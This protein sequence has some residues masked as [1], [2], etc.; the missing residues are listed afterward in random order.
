MTWV[1]DGCVTFDQSALPSA[2]IADA[3]LHRRG[4]VAE[5][6]VIECGGIL[7][8]AADCE[9]QERKE[10]HVAV[11]MGEARAEG[12]NNQ[13]RRDSGGSREEV[14]ANGSQTL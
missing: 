10:M 13:M 5:S 2:A 6:T 4:S 1:N 12:G 11:A 3:Q 7:G 9:C 14:G 8:V